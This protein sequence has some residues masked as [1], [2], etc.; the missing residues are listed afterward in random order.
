MPLQ[1][2]TFEKK[3][4]QGKIAHHNQIQHLPVFSMILNDY[5]F[6]Y[7][8]FPHLLF[9]GLRHSQPVSSFLSVRSDLVLNC[10]PISHRIFQLTTGNNCPSERD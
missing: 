7:R 2:K 5:S 9:K 8:D 6:I 3:V 4:A 10:L 1:Q